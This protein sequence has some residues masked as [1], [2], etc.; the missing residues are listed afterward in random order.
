MKKLLKKHVKQANK[1]SRFKLHAKSIGRR[2]NQKASWA[3]SKMADP[4]LSKRKHGSDGSDHDQLQPALKK[5]QTKLPKPIKTDLPMTSL[6]DREYKKALK[7]MGKCPS[8]IKPN[9]VMHNKP[10][11]N[12]SVNGQQVFEK[13]ELPKRTS[14]NKTA[15]PPSGIPT[16]NS[17]NALAGNQ[18]PTADESVAD[19]NV[20]T[21]SSETRK[22]QAT[23]HPLR[24]GI[25]QDTDSITRTNGLLS[26][27]P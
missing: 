4:A 25:N 19:E 17:F 5:P 14:P 13:W 18:P 15:S 12:K 11:T 24:S 21:T 2:P 22:I 1:H 27:G 20:N 23:A 9:L 16:S 7:E 6:V 26:S 3:A 10:Q 8:S